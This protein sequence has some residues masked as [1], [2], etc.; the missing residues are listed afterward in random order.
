MSPSP[1]LTGLLLTLWL[2]SSL[3]PGASLALEPAPSI[4]AGADRP[5]IARNGGQR[6]GGGLC[7][8]GGGGGG[9]VSYTHL[10]LPTKA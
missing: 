4:V 6:G 1:G 3:Q 7:P 2:A 8:G 9:T 10:T 5:W